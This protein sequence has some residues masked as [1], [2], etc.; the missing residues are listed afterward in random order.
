[1]DIQGAELAFL[2]SMEGYKLFE[3]VRFVFI[4]THH[5]SISGSLSTHQDCISKL[6]NLGAI[7]LTEHS[8]EE[9][10]SGDG[11]IVAS[12]QK[13]DDKMNLPLISRNVDGKY[14]FNNCA[15]SVN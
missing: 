8:I 9:S 1:M 10:F 6:I 11:L 5:E 2:E 13:N 4:S 14:L 7:I 3:K 15:I 12:F